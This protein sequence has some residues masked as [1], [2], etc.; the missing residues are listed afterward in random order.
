MPVI[1][2]STK[3]QDIEGLFEQIKREQ[4]GRL[5]MLVNNAYAGVQVPRS[6][7]RPHPSNHMK[8]NLSGVECCSRTSSTTWA[9]SSGKRS[10]PYGTPSTT[11]ASGTTPMSVIG[12]LHIPRLTLSFLPQGALLLLCPRRSAD[13]ST[14][15][16]SDRHD[17]LHGRAVV[18]LQRRIRRR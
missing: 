11:P 5:D 4:D 17:F 12:F 2:D 18:P 8:E 6:Q 14:R 7:G 15:P 1:C 13:G 3:P 10:R 16:G 9:K